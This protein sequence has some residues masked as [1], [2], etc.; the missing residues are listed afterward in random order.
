MTFG[1][2]KAKDLGKL[3][4]VSAGYDAYKRKLNPKLYVF[5]SIRNCKGTDKASR[6]DPRIMAR[7]VCAVREVCCVVQACKHS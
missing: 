2:R 7:C 5:K 1:T 6:L 3:R 4:T